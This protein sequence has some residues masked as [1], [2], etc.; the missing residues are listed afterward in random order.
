M[1]HDV[2]WFEIFAIHLSLRR[3]W[4]EH[5]FA[6]ITHSIGSLVLILLA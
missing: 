6:T 2:R 1:S 4:C 5:L 3:R